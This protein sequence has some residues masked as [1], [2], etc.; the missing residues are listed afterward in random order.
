MPLKIDTQL[1][2]TQRELVADI[3]WSIYNHLGYKAPLPLENPMYFF[4]SQHPTERA[5][6]AAAEDVFETFWGD[7][8]DYDDEED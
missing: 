1:D 5:V 3:A 8:P 4:E 2:C 7:S 6:L